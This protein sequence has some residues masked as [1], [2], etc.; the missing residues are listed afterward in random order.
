MRSRLCH[1]FAFGL[2]LPV[3]VLALSACGSSSSSSGMPGM[4][5]MSHGGQG[6]SGSGSPA[7]GAARTVTVTLSDFKITS[8]QT[9]FV[10]GTTYH[11]VVTNSSKSTTNHEFMAMQPMNGD[12][13][14]MGGMDKLALFSIDQSKLASG[15]TRTIDYT[16]TSAATVGQLEFACHV[17]S[18]YQLGMRLPITVA[19]Q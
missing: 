17:G 15:Q 1:V 4:P 14:D 13:T 19:T 6:T 2:F 3:L 11:F 7:A 12:H 5:G 16:F 18:H 8:S 10:S 9:A